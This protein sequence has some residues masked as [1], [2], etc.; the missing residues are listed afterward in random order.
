M[1]NKLNRKVTIVEDETGTKTVLIHDTIFRGR[2]PID[3]KFVEDY[4]KNYI[5]ESYE[6]LDYNEKIYIGTDLP[7]EYTGSNDT[8]SLDKKHAKAKA[9]A[10]VGIPEIIQ[11]AT[12]VSF[13]ENLKEKHA[14][15][16]SFGWYKY[17]TRFAL[18]VYNDTGALARY[19]IWS[20]ELV[21]NAAIDGKKYLYDII[22]I[23]KE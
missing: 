16:A 17:Q 2:N 6:I 19:N 22:K 10:I 11:S 14:K 7:D 15:R 3:W 9:N 21:V 20:A 4:L 5:G 18:P 23:K 1:D 12:N 8:A 13:K